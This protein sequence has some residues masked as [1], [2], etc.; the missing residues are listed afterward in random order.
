MINDGYQDALVQK[1]SQRI[2]DGVSEIAK[3]NNYIGN[4]EMGKPNSYIQKLEED[5]H[6]I[7]ENMKIS[8]YTIIP[9]ELV[10]NF[11]NDVDSI[12]VRNGENQLSLK[13]K[14]ASLN[15]AAEQFQDTIKNRIATHQ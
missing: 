5:I 9:Y 11:I 7:K 12:Q 4:P 14:K 6:Q 13:E 10:P 3:R 15:A 2:K 8:R 1:V